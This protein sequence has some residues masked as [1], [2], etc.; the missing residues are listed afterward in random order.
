MDLIE[1]IVLNKTFGLEYLLIKSEKY[2]ALAALTS[3]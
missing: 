2:Y 3:R 1:F